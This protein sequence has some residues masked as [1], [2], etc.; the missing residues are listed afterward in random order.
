MTGLAV[1]GASGRMGR[2][3]VEYILT[4]SDVKLVGWAVE[5]RVYAEESF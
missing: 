5:S 3:L 1:A 2:L 4:A